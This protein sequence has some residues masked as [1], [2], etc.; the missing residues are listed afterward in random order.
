VIDTHLASVQ[1][2]EWKLQVEMQSGKQFGASPEVT[3]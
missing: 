3:R 1:L 2:T